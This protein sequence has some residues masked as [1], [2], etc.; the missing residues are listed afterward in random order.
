MSDP[1]LSR[2]QREADAVCTVLATLMAHGWEW[3][4]AVGTKG[5]KGT[6]VLAAA[7]AVAL[8]AGGPGQLVKE[9]HGEVPR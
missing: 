9:A 3:F 2:E 4:S 1:R 8:G 7:L 5:S 6:K